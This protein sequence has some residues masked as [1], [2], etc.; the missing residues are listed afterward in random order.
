MNQKNSR[1][2]ERV[3]T[4]LKQ[5]KVP[6]SSHGSLLFGTEKSG[7]LK[8]IETAKG[9]LTDDSR[10]LTGEQAQPPK[11][12]RYLNL[13]A[14]ALRRPEVRSGLP[15]SISGL[16]KA[17]LFLG[18]TDADRWVGATVKINSSQLQGARGLRIGIV[19]MQH[20]TSDA[21]RRDDSKNLIICPIPHDASFMQTFYEAWQVVRTFIDADAQVPKPVA[22]PR[23]AS[24]QVAKYLYDRRTF[25]VFDIIE[26]LFPLSQP[27]LLATTARNVE[28]QAQVPGET[29]VETMLAPR[30]MMV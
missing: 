9:V 30:P 27:G 4:A 14:A 15:Y 13:L 10:V 2:A 11:L 7:A 21:V 29:L 25:P 18:N 17:D 8:L 26:A 28:T 19:P 6:G 22:L 3:T 12:K 16:W 23:P 1:V 24:R 5:C 20:G